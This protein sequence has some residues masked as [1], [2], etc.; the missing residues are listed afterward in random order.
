VFRVV[1]VWLTVALGALAAV[2]ALRRLRR[3]EADDHF[4]AVSHCYD[5]WL[6]PHY[7]QHLVVKKTVPM[8][9][10]ITAFQPGA[11]GLDLGCGRGWY[12]REMERAGARPVGLDLSALQLVAAREYLGREAPLLRGSVFQVPVRSGTFDFAYIIN[13]LH[14]LPSPRHQEVALEEIGRVVRPGGFV[15]VHEMNVRN[16][17]FHFY[18]S[19]I[20]PIL[21]GIEEGTEHYMNPRRLPPIAGLRLVAVHHFTFLPDFVSPGV[22]SAVAPIERWLEKSPMGPYAAHFLAVFERL[23]HKA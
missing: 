7:R 13:A 8:L 3:P 2:L 5:A 23:G 22:L 16:L 21:K 6:P 1:T 12:M 10:Q 18:L 19:Y 20:F 17:L 11:R 15:F 9:E 14:H 4:D